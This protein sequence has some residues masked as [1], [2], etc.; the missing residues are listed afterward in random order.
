[1][2]KPSLR[3][4]FLLLSLSLLGKADWHNDYDRCVKT[5][6]EPAKHKCVQHLIS[7]VKDTALTFPKLNGSWLDRFI[8]W[9]EYLGIN[10][11][12]Y[13]KA[14]SMKRVVAE[15][16]RVLETNA[17]SDDHGYFALAEYYEGLGPQW[18]KWSARARH[19]GN[20]CAGGG[21]DDDD[22]SDDA[23][24]EV[25]QAP[26][27]VFEAPNPR[28]AV[29]QS[30]PSLPNS[31]APRTNPNVI[32]QR[33]DVQSNLQVIQ[34]NAVP[35]T[36]RYGQTGTLSFSL[37]DGY[38]ESIIR[39]TVNCD[40]LAITKVNA[41]GRTSFP[42]SQE[43]DGV[44]ARP[45]S[46]ILLTVEPASNTGGVGIYGGTSSCYINA[47]TTNPPNTTNSSTNTVAH[48]GVQPKQ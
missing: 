1:M 28:G 9:D 43:V 4:L 29:Q 13:Q 31:T 30:Q 36:I 24:S 46:V 7:H 48:I 26:A 39:W 3:A 15:G 11:A 44:D 22:T 19:V 42:S 41:T 2:S 20:F 12:D 16:T 14:L 21:C 47:A 6:A 8:S 40:F 32:P 45:G 25:A 37:V 18:K 38:R 5:S 10:D 35:T 17:N 27:T 23:T 33:S 34:V